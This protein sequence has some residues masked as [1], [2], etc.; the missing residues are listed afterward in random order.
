MMLWWFGGGE[1]RTDGDRGRD[2]REK[3]RGGVML[4]VTVLL[5]SVQDMTHVVAY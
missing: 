3:E 5:S 1:Q 2:K 4:S